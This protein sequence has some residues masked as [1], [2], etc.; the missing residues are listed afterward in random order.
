MHSIKLEDGT[1]LENLELNGNNY[2]ANIAIEDSVFEGNLGVIEISDG[3]TTETYQ[4]M[5]LM[6]NIVRDGRSWIVLGQKSQDEIEKETLNN[7]IA[8]LQ[9]IIDTMLGVE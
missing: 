1:M 6:S 8:E 2:I 5:K 4:D 7:K 9:Q 3:E